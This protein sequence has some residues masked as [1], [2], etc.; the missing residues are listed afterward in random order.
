MN[1][2][3]ISCAL[4]CYLL[5]LSLGAPLRHGEF[6]RTQ[7]AAKDDLAFVSSTRQ[8][9]STEQSSIDHSDVSGKEYE[10]TSHQT[11]QNPLASSQEIVPGGFAN[12]ERETEYWQA[13]RLFI[14]SL[15]YGKRHSQSKPGSQP[16]LTVATPIPTTELM[17]LTAEHEHAKPN[18]L[19]SAPTLAPSWIDALRQAAQNETEKRPDRLEP[20]NTVNRLPRKSHGHFVEKQQ[21]AHAPKATIPAISKAQLNEAVSTFT[22]NVPLKSSILLR[23]FGPEITVLS[24]FILVPITVLVVEAIEVLWRRWTP[25]RFPRRGRGRIRLTGKERRLQAWSDW[26]REKI[27][28]NESRHWWGRSRRDMGRKLAFLS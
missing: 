11:I 3:S 10:R 20:T 9:I 6:V 23:Q 14:E 12:G 7:H 5:P 27:L 4:L 21:M 13:L 24:V 19:P 28:K 8:H 15:I 18:T 16:S 22:F 26:E 25:E 17:R 2:F 1:A